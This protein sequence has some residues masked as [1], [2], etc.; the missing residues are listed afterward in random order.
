MRTSKVLIGVSMGIIGCKFYDSFKHKIKP[1]IVKVV[2]N[3]ILIEERTKE[4]LKNTKD[5]AL[6]LNKKSYRMIN[7]GDIQDNDADMAENIDELKKQLEEIQ[8]QLSTL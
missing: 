8:K 7:E 2:E 1:T 6:E 5:T 3:A 4:F